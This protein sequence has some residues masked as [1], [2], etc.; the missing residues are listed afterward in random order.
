[1]IAVASDYDASQID[2]DSGVTGALVSD[3]LDTLDTASTPSVIAAG[4]DNNQ[5]GTAYTLVLTDADNKTVYMD[6][7][8]ANVLTIPTNASV[9]FAVGTKIN[10]MM[11]G[12]GV[13]SITG[14]T[15]VTVNGVSAGSGDINNQYQGVTLAKRATNTW[16]VIGDIGTVS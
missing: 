10:V 13:T 3:A 12:A 9:A 7:A 4:T 5:T 11:E 16:L 14:D 8:A 15:G 6:N 1:M 2:N